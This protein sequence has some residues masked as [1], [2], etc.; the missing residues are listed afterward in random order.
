MIGVKHFGWSDYAVFAVMLIICMLIGVYFAWK[1]YQKRN[2]RKGARRGSE[3]LNYLVGGRKMKTIPVAMSLIASLV[4][5]IGLLGTSTEIYLFGSGYMFIH[6]AMILMALVL[7]FV[8]L[9][10]FHELKLT[11]MYEYLERRFDKNMRIL[12]S[13]MFVVKTVSM[14]CHF[15]SQI[16]RLSF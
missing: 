6:I 4:S 11:S 10:V 14:S 15:C 7:H 3:A 16:R 9:P 8:L 5:G 1:D 12:G 13:V 2:A